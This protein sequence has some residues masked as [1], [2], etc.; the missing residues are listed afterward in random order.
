MPAGPPERR[1]P[2]RLADTLLDPTLP[3]TKGHALAVLLGLWGADIAETRADCD[4]SLSGALEC[5]A[6]V[7]SWQKLGR[8]DVPA[9]LELADPQGQP[10]YGVLTALTPSEGTLRFGDRVV[11]APLAEVDAFWDGA[12]M[13]VWR[14]PP[15]TLPL[16]RGARGPAAD[17]L[18]QRFARTDGS[19]G[20]IERG[21][22]YDDTLWK[23][24]VAFQ[25]A[26]SLEPDGVVG[27]ET[28][29]LLQRAEWGSDV[30]RLSTGAR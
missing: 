12:F 24:V 30:P 14:P 11:T 10:R 22:P 21:Q 23:R 4:G 29:I 27:R 8:L 16:R 19:R 13:V 26:R 20:P 5:V 28:A 3:A 17:W 9:A 2:L 7:G 1:P 6:G 18:R 15:G 25:Q